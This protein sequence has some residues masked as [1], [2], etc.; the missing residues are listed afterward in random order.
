M[1]TKWGG[2]KSII[3][4]GSGQ[5]IGFPFGFSV[6]NFHFEKNYKGDTKII[7]GMNSIF[8]NGYKI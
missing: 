1:I 6:G 7:M 2:V 3:I 4:Y 5:L 8:K